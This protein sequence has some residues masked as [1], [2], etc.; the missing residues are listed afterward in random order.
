[1]N[2]NRDMKRALRYHGDGYRIM[3]HKQPDGFTQP[4]GIEMNE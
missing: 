1:M 4:I 3:V 2:I